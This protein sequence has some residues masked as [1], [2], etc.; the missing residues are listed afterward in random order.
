MSVLIFCR[1]LSEAFLIIRRIQRD[2]AINMET[3][4]TEM[5]VILA[6]F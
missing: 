4:S 2:T 5:P 3:S 1:T 6:G